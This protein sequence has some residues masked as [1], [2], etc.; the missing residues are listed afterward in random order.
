VTAVPQLRLAE[1]DDDQLVTAIR[2]DPGA[3]T[4]LYQRYADRVYARVTHLLG[5]V[6]ERED[7]MQQIFVGLHRALPTFRGDASL[8]TFLYRITLN[9]AFDHM[10]SRRRRPVEYSSD[11]L[12]RLLDHEPSPEARTSGREELR[13]ALTLVAQL[14]PARRIAFALVAIEGLDLA[15]A[16]EL[17][18]ISV[19]AT[20]QRVLQARRDL[21]DMLAKARRAR[22]AS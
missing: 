19:D 2:A 15:Q 20:K 6:A 12:D 4:I 16:A 11:A 7:L 14:T 10:R 8:S 5:P 13:E 17:L 22:R 3:F 18:D 21:L 9:V 1:L